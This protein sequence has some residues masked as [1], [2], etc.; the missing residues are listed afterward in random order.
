ML[1]NRLEGEVC[2]AV[3]S[4]RLL[5]S[6][7]VLCFA[8]LTLCVCI[9]YSS[10]RK[11]KTVCILVA[12]NDDVSRVPRVFTFIWVLFMMCWKAS[13]YLLPY[14]STPDW[15]ECIPRPLQ[16]K[17]KPMNSF[18]VYTEKHRTSFSET[19]VVAP[20]FIV[21]YG[22]VLPTYVQPFVVRSTSFLFIYYS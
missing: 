2:I 8:Q 11:K 21:S 14:F 18:E 12:L 13:S 22:C 15:F 1:D 6:V 7:G 10:T 4:Y 16:Y 3:S 9:T 20:L 17:S 19:L 5:Y